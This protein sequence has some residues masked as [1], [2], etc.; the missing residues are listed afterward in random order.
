MQSSFEGA[1]REYIDA[2]RLYSE[3]VSPRGGPLSTWIDNTFTVLARPGELLEMPPE[4]G[5]ILLRVGSGTPRLGI[6][7]VIAHPSLAQWER[8]EGSNISVIHEGTGLY[9][10]MIHCGALPRTRPDL[11]A[12]RIVDSTRRMPPGQ[13]L[14]RPKRWSQIP[15]QEIA[16]SMPV[17]SVGVPG[18]VNGSPTVVLQSSEAEPSPLL[19]LLAPSQPER[20][21]AWSGEIYDRL[22][23]VPDS[24]SAVSDAWYEAALNQ[25]RHELTMRFDDPNDPGLSLRRQRLRGLFA[26]VPGAHAKQLYA[27]L[28]EQPTAD[29][30]S[31][32]FHGRLS[33]ETQ[34]EML[35]LLRQRF[36]SEK[37]PAQPAPQPAPQPAWIWPTHPLPPDAQGRFQAALAALKQDV[38]ATTDP[39]AWRYR[40]WLAKLEAGA[41]D[42]VIT[43]S[44]ICPRTSGAVGAGLIVGPCDVATGGVLAIDQ[45]ELES[46][47]NSEGVERANQRLKFMTYMRTD[48]LFSSMIS[49]NQQLENFRMLHDDVNR[50]VSK[51]D[52][53]GDPGLGG[54]SAMPPAYRAI[55]AWIG[56]K[57]DDEGSVYSCR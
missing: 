30:L 32:L 21:V 10:V 7:S 3:V 48:I 1:T 47:I 5:D 45:R 57:Q 2:E 41:D 8:F 40:C 43:W 35:G 55:K 52:I 12:S 17:W 37:E 15:E 49:R 51:L 34:H 20:P 50:A 56:H 24:E 27:R 6:V 31:R 28:G 25:L 46:A 4:N 33:P 19:P 11:L 36:P 23:N 13:A 18:V 29:E 54:G 38:A 53:W 42:R 22:S 16:E 26:S 9:A 44:A 14:L 39:R